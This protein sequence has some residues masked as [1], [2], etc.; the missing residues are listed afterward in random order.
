M[1]ITDLN[2]APDDRLQPAS[3]NSMQHAEK[4]SRNGCSGGKEIF[5]RGA[6]GALARAPRGGGHETASHGEASGGRWQA[7]P[8]DRLRSSLCRGRNALRRTRCRVPAR[9]QAAA[10]L[11]ALTSLARCGVYD[12][13]QHVLHGAQ[14]YCLT[15]LTI[16]PCLWSGN[17]QFE[18]R[19][20]L[21]HR[22]H[23]LPDT[24]RHPLRNSN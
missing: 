15:D 2:T 10:A 14:V 22:K 12:A 1:V 16:I 3:C 24:V 19:P 9:R 21:Y 23:A 6:R 13:C 11:G 17:R 7:A 20:L 4:K 5:V 18:T 8:R